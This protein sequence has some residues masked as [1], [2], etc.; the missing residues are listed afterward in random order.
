[1]KYFDPSQRCCKCGYAATTRFHKQSN[2]MQRKYIR[3]DY[4]WHEL[5]LDGSNRNMLCPR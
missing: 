5:P 4:T 2:T 3:C 1:M